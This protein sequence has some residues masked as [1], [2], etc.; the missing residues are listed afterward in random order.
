MAKAGPED[1][2]INREIDAPAVG[3]CL[4]GQEDV[5]ELAGVAR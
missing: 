5:T 4:A 1:G 2:K 3:L